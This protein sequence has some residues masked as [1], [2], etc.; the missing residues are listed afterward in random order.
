MAIYR[1]SDSLVKCSPESYDSLYQVSSHPSIKAQRK[2]NAKAVDSLEKSAATE[3]LNRLQ[4]PS[5]NMVFQP[6]IL[7]S[8]IG[9]M[10]FLTVAMPP[11]FLLYSLPR[12]I[13]VESAHLLMLASNWLFHQGNNYLKKPLVI[14][15]EK[16]QQLLFFMYQFV[17]RVVKP[18]AELA[19]QLKQF[20]KDSGQRFWAA[21]LPVFSFPQKYIK[22]SLKKGLQPLQTILEKT[23][24]LFEKIG[25][26]SLDTTEL[27][28]SNVRVPEEN[29]L[30]EE[31]KGFQ[32][33]MENLPQERMT[34]AV[35][36]IAASESMLE[37]TIDYCK[38]R[39]AF[40]QA[41][42]SFQNSKFK[43]AEMK[44]EIEIGRVFIDDC[45]MRLNAK[46]L[47][48]VKAAMAKWWASDLQIKVADQCLQLHGGNGYMME[49]PIA[50][51]YTDA[52]VQSI[53]GGTNEIMKEIIGRSL[54]F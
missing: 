38:E 11:Y 7:F 12:W 36:A 1:S 4:R 17:K 15:L 49:Y 35:G 50:R 2:Q 23:K 13:L 41:I 33:L 27:F 6:S 43:L 3:A 40:G 32:Y 5:E 14:A 24:D 45:I 39:K 10:V 37:Y 29:I 46:T 8:R 52:R 22:N 16:T 51:A 30:G 34:I 48:P 19:I 42:G 28:F 44:T 54:G 25:Q 31:G 9:K 20:F 26:K 47:T 21:F 18:V 53:Y